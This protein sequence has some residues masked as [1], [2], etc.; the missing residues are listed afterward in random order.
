MARVRGSSC[1]G[2]GS[3]QYDGQEGIEH[4]KWGALTYTTAAR[5]QRRRWRQRRRWWQRRRWRQ[6]EQQQQQQQQQQQRRRCKQQQQSECTCSC[7]VLSDIWV[8]ESSDGLPPTGLATP[9]NCS[10]LAL[11]AGGRK[12]GGKNLHETLGVG[13]PARHSPLPALLV[14]G[15][16]QRRL[17]GQGCCTPAVPAPYAA[18]AACPAQPRGSSP[19]AAAP[20]RTAPHTQPSLSSPA[21]RQ[22]PPEARM[23]WCSMAP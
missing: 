3:G 10:L 8:G 9:T 21:P 2:H 14:P 19:P 5:Q 11:S 7:R 18:A 22:H 16:P 17:A 1:G 12:P 4:G 6:Q 20:L 13:S 15:Q 23:E